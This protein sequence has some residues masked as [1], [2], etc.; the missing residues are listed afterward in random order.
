MSDIQIIIPAALLTGFLAFLLEL[1]WRRTIIPQWLSRKFLHISA[2]GACAIVP[3]FLESLTLLFYLVAS[4]EILLIYLVASGKLFAENKSNKSWGIAFFPIPY[5]ALLYIF[6]NERE[7]IFIPMIILAVSDALACIIGTLS[8]KKFYILTG[9]KKS[10]I[11][12]SVFFLSSFILLLIFWN[13]QQNNV[14]YVFSLLIIALILS[15]LEALGS[16]GS[17]NLLIPSGAALLMFI[18][19][20]NPSQLTEYILLLSLILIFLVLMLKMRWL[21]M[22]GALSAALLGFFVWHFAGWEFLAPLVWFLFSSTVIGKIYRVEIQEGFEKKHG[23]ARDYIQVLSNSWLFLVLAIILGLNPENNELIIPKLY[24]VMAIATADTWAS[25]LGGK[26]SNKVIYLFT[27]KLHPKGISG[28][29]SFIGTLSGF[30]GG[31]SIACLGYFM[32]HLSSVS[33]IVIITIVGF[34]GMIV[35]SI[36]A[37]F[38][39]KRYHNA[40]LDIYADEQKEGFT[41]SENYRILTNDHV[42]MLSITLALVI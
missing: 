1:S 3:L 20:K 39:Q 16:K 25:E 28:G 34:A 24:A 27:M 22:S 21:Q 37:A 29:L 40:T 18:E 31:L 17:D 10:L 13:S 8:A 23:K 12:S 30:L 7:F 19:T 42:N 11:G 26:F 38:L 35:D 15:A 14:Q 32:G 2:V 41:N 36:I 9:D 5:L 6:E 33:S 4:F